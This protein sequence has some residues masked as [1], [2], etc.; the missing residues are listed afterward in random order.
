MKN[1]GILVDTDHGVCVW[2]RSGRGT[3]GTSG[4]PPPNPSPRPHPNPKWRH[5]PARAELRNP[6]GEVIGTATFVQGEGSVML[7]AEVMGVER[8]RRPT[9]FTSMRSARVS[10]TSRPLAAIS[11]PR[12][13][14]TACPPTPRTPRR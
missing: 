3:G 6:E 8:E 2:L 7:T 1:L 12:A 10:R 11:I 4:A 5:Q 9:A 13:P 14:S